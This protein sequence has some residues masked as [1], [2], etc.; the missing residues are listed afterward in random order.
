MKIFHIK[1]DDTGRE[2]EVELRYQLG[3]HNWFNGKE[4]RRGYYVSFDI[5]ERGDGC[6][7]RSLGTPLDATYK[8]GKILCKEV[9]RKSQKVQTNIE[10]SLDFTELAVAW[11]RREYDDAFD[12]IKIAG[13]LA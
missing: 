6:V 10:N 13:E 11:F 8:T 9:K 12:A 2:I 5:V 7:R 3:G 4:E 1:I